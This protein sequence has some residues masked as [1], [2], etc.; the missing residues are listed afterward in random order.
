MFCPPSSIIEVFSTL[1]PRE[2]PETKGMTY[3]IESKEHELEKG[4][5]DAS[6]ATEREAYFPIWLWIMSRRKM[7]LHINLSECLPKEVSCGPQSDIR[8]SG[9][10]CR[11]CYLK[12]NLQHIWN[13][14][15]K[16]ILATF[17]SMGRP[18]QGMK[19]ATLVKMLPLTRGSSM[20]KL[21]DT[22]YQGLSGVG[23]GR[24]SPTS[25]PECLE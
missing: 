6:R 17:L 2:L 23:N 5:Q 22:V 25:C 14:L 15:F 19:W 8:C 16:K 24:C 1:Y 21:R 3:I 12:R 9:N 18:V 10:L 20:M 13:M 7:K 11:I 4:M